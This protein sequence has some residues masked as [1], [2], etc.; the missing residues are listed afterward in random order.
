[1]LSNKNDKTT[2]AV[3]FLPKIVTLRQKLGRHGKFL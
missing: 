2:F 3:R 1:M